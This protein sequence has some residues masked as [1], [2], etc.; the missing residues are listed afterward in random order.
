M[1]KNYLMSPSIILV[2]WLI[3]SF[4]FFGHELLIAYVG[5][6]GLVYVE[7]LPGVSVAK[8]CLLQGSGESLVVKNI[9]RQ[10]GGNYR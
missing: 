8:T 1:A 7:Q 5:N 10:G 2:C 9:S 4:R 3:N 6:N